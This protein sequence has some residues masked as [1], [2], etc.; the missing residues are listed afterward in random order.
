MTGKSSVRRSS[1][2]LLVAGFVSL[3]YAIS[4]AAQTGG[5]A[6]PVATAASGGVA[7]PGTAEPSPAG[8]TTTTARSVPAPFGG[9]S[10]GVAPV[11]AVAAATG[12]TATTGPSGATGTTGPMDPEELCDIDTQRSKEPVAD[13]AE[14]DPGGCVIAEDPVPV[15]DTPPADDGQTDG[16]VGA[17]IEGLAAEPPVSVSG[18][19]LPFTGG[20]MNAVLLVGMALLGL[21]LIAL[22][23]AQLLSARAFA[24]KTP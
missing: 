19:Q 2:I 24:L 21:G 3:A 14:L 8:V 18:A 11:S 23:S 20:D 22:G 10:A 6:P 5:T 17:G 15:S 4:A 1:L 9:I 12:P 16:D 13:A 7:A